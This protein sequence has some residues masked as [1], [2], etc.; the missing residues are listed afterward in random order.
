MYIEESKNAYS[1][2]FKKL[3][4]DT[5]IDDLLAPL[6]EEGRGRGGG[7]ILKF[8]MGRCILLHISEKFFLR[9]KF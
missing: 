5:K 3:S 2:S 6:G 9:P 8:Q 7:A 1:M 4:V